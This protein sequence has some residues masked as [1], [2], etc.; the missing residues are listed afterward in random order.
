[1]NFALK[2]GFPIAAMLKI[3][4]FTVAIGGTLPAD[5]DVKTGVIEELNDVDGFFSY[6][7]TS[8]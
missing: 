6:S 8:L 3:E 4:I 5:F 2:L 1:M 7:Q